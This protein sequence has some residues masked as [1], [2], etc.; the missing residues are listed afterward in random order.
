[1]CELECVNESMHLFACVSSGWGED[2]LELVY[3][4][5]N[6]FVSL[7]VKIVC[8]CESANIR[9]CMYFHVIYLTLT[10]TSVCVCVV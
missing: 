4:S 6:T 3:E 7:S 2:M 1:M 5:I 8:I 9:T 10:C